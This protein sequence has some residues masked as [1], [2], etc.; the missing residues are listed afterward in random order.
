ML[1]L[2]QAQNEKINMVQIQNQMIL[3]KLGKSEGD[4]SNIN[5]IMQQATLEELDTILDN[6]DELQQQFSNQL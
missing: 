4:N 2:I 6:A 3:E 1:K 5:Q